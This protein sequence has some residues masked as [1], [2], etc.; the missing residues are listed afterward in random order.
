MKT[1]TLCVL[2]LSGL[3]RQAPDETASWLKINWWGEDPAALTQLQEDEKLLKDAKVATGSK[4]LTA[5]LRG[6][7]PT[8]EDEQKVGELFKQLGA[9]KFQQREQATAAL[10]AIGPK[11]IPLLRRLLPGSPLEVRMRAERCLKAL[12]AK[13]PAALASAAVRLLKARPTPDVV[14]VLLDFAPYAPDDFVAEDLLDAAYTLGVKGNKLDPALDGALND[15]H[16]A[17]RAIAAVLLGRFGTDIQRKTVAE[18]LKDKDMEV[19]FR[20]AQG[21]LARGERAALPVLVDLLKSAPLELAERAEEMLVQAAVKTAPKAALGTTEGARK[22]CHE[23]WTGWLAE[24]QAKVDL[25]KVDIGFPLPSPEF[26]ARAVVRELIDLMLKPKEV[27]VAKV[28]RLTDVP[29]YQAGRPPLNTRD[30][31]LD[32]IKREQP[33]PEDFKIKT[34]IGKVELLSDFLPRAMGDEK[35]FLGKFAAAEVRV[36]H[37]RFEIDFGG[38]NV[39]ATVPLFVRVNGARGRVFGVGQPTDLTPKQ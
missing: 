2:L 6:L 24:H 37:M 10:T 22:A 9:P 26:R 7:A 15:A 18:L 38:M 8:T 4:E 11:A 28:L 36:V 17:R 33:P 13:S 16:P 31:W 29:F 25:S 27:T 20:A 39:S 30:E 3:P 1:A 5:Y 23:A 12:E 32:E 35:A 34:S 19:R 21:L 14:A